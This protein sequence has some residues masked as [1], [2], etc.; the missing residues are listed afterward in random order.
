MIKRSAFFLITIALSM[1]LIAGEEFGFKPDCITIVEGGAGVKST[2]KIGTFLTDVLVCTVQVPSSSVSLSSQLL[3]FTSG[4]RQKT[5]SFTATKGTVPDGKD[6]ITIE[7]KLQCPTNELLEP[8][9]NTVLKLV[10]KK[11]GDSAE[12][13]PHLTQLVKGMDESSSRV[14]KNI[15]Y[16]LY[17]NAGDQFEIISDRILESAV[18]LELRDDFYIGKVLLQTPL[19]F[20]NIT[21]SS[22]FVPPRRRFRWQV[23]EDFSLNNQRNSFKIDFEIRDEYVMIG[24][25][26]GERSLNVRVLKVHQNIGKNYLN[27]M[28]DQSTS[29]GQELDKYHGGLFG[30]ISN[31]QYR[32]YDPVQKDEHTAV[33]KINN[34]LV[35]SI[36]RER[37]FN[38]DQTCYF[39]NM[40]DILYPKSIEMFKRMIN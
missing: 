4:N 15:C 27:I 11:E 3:I 17:G 36:F 18:V 32:F 37:N 2:V 29:K 24:I 12:K 38:E 28:I 25:K 13:D 34:R 22:I 30:E 40:N 14:R 26:R 35:K 23:A 16:D 5:L 6:S 9:E 39:M 10:I 21:T 7:V 19:G 33:V 31:K 8:I 20:L 1:N